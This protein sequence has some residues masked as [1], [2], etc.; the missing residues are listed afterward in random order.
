MERELPPD[1]MEGYL[2]LLP[3]PGS[4]D[5]AEPGEPMFSYLAK[6]SRRSKT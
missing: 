6:T 5:F 2:H 4:M 3:D 1:E